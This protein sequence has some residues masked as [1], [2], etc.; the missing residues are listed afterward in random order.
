MSLLLYGDG[1][2]EKKTEEYTDITAWVREELLRHAE[3]AYGEFH[4]SLVPGLES[5]LGGPG[6]QHTENREKGGKNRLL[7]I[8]QRGRLIRV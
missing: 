5:M 4:K 2:M 8:C 6:A 7:R 1:D 3:E